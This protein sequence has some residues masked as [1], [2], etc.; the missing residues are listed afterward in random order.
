MSQAEKPR[1]YRIKNESKTLFL[2]Y[3]LSVAS[4]RES[5]QKICTFCPFENEGKQKQID[6]LQL[7]AIWKQFFFTCL[8]PPFSSFSSFIF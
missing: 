4:Q 3:I 2:N 1:K 5:N 7:L 8:K 6:S